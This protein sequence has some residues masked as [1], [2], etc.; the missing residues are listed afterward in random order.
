MK[1][2]HHPHRRPV[3]HRKGAMMPVVAF[4]LPVIMIFIGYSVNLAYMEL[5]KTE[6]RLSCD[7]AA[8]AAL[9]NFGSTQQQSNAI[10]FGQSVA[11]NNTVVGQS[12]T[13]PSANFKFGNAS[14]QGTGSYTFTVGGTPTN[15]VRVIGSTT[16]SLPFGAM[17][18]SGTYT[19]SQTAIAT[20]ISHDI[21]LVL[22]RS[23]SMA[24]DL[25]GNQFVYPADRVLYSALQ[26][27]F[28][29]PSPTASRWAALTSA[30]NS[31]ITVLQ[32]RNLD[33]KVSL[34]TYAEAYSLGSY[35]STQASLDVN[36]TSNYNSIL[37]SMQTWGNTPLLGDTNIA[38]GLAL[39]QGE[40]TGARA[41]T[42]ADRTI[43]L[44]TDGVATTGN[45]NIA[46]LTSSYR[47]G[48]SIVTHV[49][50]FGGEAA[51]GTV[52]T[53]MTSPASSGNG[54]L[55]NPAT[56]AQLTSAFQTIADSLPAVLIN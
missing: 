30:V 24:F 37:T 8:K 2:Q 48:S 53:S 46:G 40:L 6:L 21:V 44:L 32:A 15:S 56:A 49:I 10:S 26:S 23:A 13:I 42:T 31:F 9:I 12:V 50:T 28:T 51:A 20:R 1:L 52:N 33:V 36:L 39:A 55:L 11:L 29:A 4:M 19:C 45:T 17:T 16:V 18:P 41:R 25:S 34:V 5:A 3:A 35:N 54:P 22:D 43:I 14:K 38:A 27:Y 7:S 47:T